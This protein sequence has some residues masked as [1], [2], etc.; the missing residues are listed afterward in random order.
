MSLHSSREER[1][2]GRRAVSIDEQRG[3]RVRLAINDAVALFLSIESLPERKRLRD[4]LRKKITIDLL[5]FPRENPDRNDRFWIAVTDGDEFPPRIFQFH[6]LPR[7]K[8]GREI[9][10]LV[11]I[12]PGMSLRNPVCNGLIDP[13][14]IH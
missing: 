2:D 12:D 9:G 3:Q 5:P 14:R 8:I 6:Q 1:N 7:R 13:K 10:K 11:T 4:S